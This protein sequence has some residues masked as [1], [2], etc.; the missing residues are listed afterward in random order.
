M[1]HDRRF[2]YFALFPNPTHVSYLE[3]IVTS[4]RINVVKV[5]MKVLALMNHL[6]QRS[7]SLSLYGRI[8]V[9][10]KSLWLNYSTLQCNTQV[11]RPKT[12]T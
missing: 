8:H 1:F 9:C 12:V 6:L 3:L 2:R 4:S 10:L 11:Q 7:L 5:K